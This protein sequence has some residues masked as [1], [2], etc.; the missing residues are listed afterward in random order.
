M[1][2]FETVYTMVSKIPRGRVA[3]YGQIARLA[4]NPRASRI[5]GCALHMCPASGGIPCHRV[6]NRE[7]RLAPADAFGGAGMQKSLLAAEGVSVN[8][9]GYV[10]VSYTHLDVYKRQTLLLRA[11]LGMTAV[12]P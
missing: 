1:N 9:D 10:A 4:G 2:F 12:S 7:G 6:V 3:T 5:V 11:S 8:A